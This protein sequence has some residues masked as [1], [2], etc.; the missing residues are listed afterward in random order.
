LGFAP[1]AAAKAK[2][3]YRGRR[4]GRESASVE[5]E[6]LIDENTS[7]QVSREDLLDFVQKFK[8]SKESAAAVK[9]RK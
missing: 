7:E 2:A 8:E 5:V 1:G 3:T 4:G 6:A 9:T